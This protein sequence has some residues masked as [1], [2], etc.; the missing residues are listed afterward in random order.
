MT[1][2]LVVGNGAREH[3]IAE[4]MKASGAN[5]VSLMAAKNPGIDAIS[6]K[7]IIHKLQDF[8]ILKPKLKNIDMA[9]IGSED[10]LAAGMVNFLEDE[11]EIPCIGPRK[12]VAL[13]ESSKSFARKLLAKYKINANPNFAIC[14]CDTQVKEFL[15]NHTQVAVKPDGL[16][17]GKGVRLSGEQLPTKESVIN[18][19][20]QCIQKDGSVVLEERLFGKEFTLQVFV[21]GRKIKVMPIVQ[22][23]KRAYNDDKGPNTGSM[24]SYSCVNHKLPFLTKNIIEKATSI[25]QKTV[26]ALYKETSVHYKGILYGQFMLVNQIPYIIEFNVRFGDPEAINVLSLLKSNFIDIATNIIQG[27]LKDI[28]FEKKATTCVYLVPKGYP[29]SPL[30][31]Q[32]II[33]NINPTKLPLYYASVYLKEGS[34]YTTRSRSMAIVATGLSVEE[35]RIAVY[36]QIKKYVKSKNLIIEKLF[37]RTDIAKNI[38]R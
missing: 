28:E 14:R 15:Q 34:I 7:T 35:S 31:E 21:D 17:G 8:S 13:I 33:Q 29:T 2:I 20:K 22:D 38:N 23:Y 11:L 37:Y 18:Y 12:E 9:I 19:A 32:P 1:N 25:L 36:N 10:P 5:L 30:I 4:K 27:K 26:D 3:I 24:G 16:T 6:K